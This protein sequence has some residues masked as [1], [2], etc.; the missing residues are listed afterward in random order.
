MPKTPRTFDLWMISADTV[1][2]GMPYQ[3]LSGWVEQGRV[4]R[5]DKVR[6]DGDTAWTL[7]GDHPL[8]AD[9]LPR[10]TTR[11]TTVAPVSVTNDNVP[12]PSPPLDDLDIEVEWKKPSRDDDD[13][14]D[15]IPLIDISLVLLIFFMMTS[16]VSALSPV[17]VPS[18]K[19]AP[20][21]EDDK[22]AFTVHVDK[23][24]NG[25]VFFAVR[26]GSGSPLPDD[27]HLP[28]IN[29]MMARMDLLLAGVS[30]PPE[31]RIACHQDLPRMYV[32]E[33][34]KELEIRRAKGQIAF[35]AA[36]VNE[37]PK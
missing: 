29:Q 30:R 3:V 5:Q 21:L 34:A 20:E 11:F 33:V 28:S 36:E 9:F 14:V 1:Y 31:V 25:D 17:N 2:R 37:A 32:R 19:N 22:T 15:M 24:S 13:E 16:V 18:M 35:Y 12:P 10:T 26:V 23:E 4:G 7:I 27:N 8:L 6:A